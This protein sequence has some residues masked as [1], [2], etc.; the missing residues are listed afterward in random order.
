MV[1]KGSV[2]KTKWSHIPITFSAEDINLAYFSH[3]DAMVVTIHIDKWDVTRII[4]GSGSQAE[5]LFMTALRN[6]L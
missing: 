4:I 3:T 1:V 6:W 5:I 2:T